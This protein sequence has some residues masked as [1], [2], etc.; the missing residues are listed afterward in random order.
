MMC[1]EQKPPAGN[2]GRIRRVAWK[3]RI[4]AFSV[5]SSANIAV[6]AGLQLLTLPASGTVP[7]MAGA[8]WYPCAVAPGQ[9]VIGTFVLRAARD[10]AVLGT[11]LPLV[12]LSHGKTDPLGI[13]FEAD[14]FRNV[15]VPIQLWRSEQGGDGVTPESVAQIAEALPSKPEFHTVPNSAHFAF[16]SP[17]SIEVSLELPALCSDAPGFDRVQ[18]HRD[19]NAQVIGFF[20]NH[21]PPAEH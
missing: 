14:S 10:C 4:V 21:L 7:R 3:S 9:V 11:Q 1:A 15:V 2:V 6:G 20:R 13:F 19:L 18:F 5:L 12:V 8:V 16:L 17:C